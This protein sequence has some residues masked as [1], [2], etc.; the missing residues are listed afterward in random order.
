MIKVFHIITRLDIGGAEKVALNISKS[1]SGQV[2]YH[3]VEVAKGNS[4]YSEQFKKEAQ[5]SGITIHC[6]DI[7]NVRMA[8]L[9]FPLRFR[10][11]LKKYHPDVIHT[12]T[13][14]PD[15]SL[16]LSSL[17]QCFKSNDVKLV[18][19]IHNNQLWNKWK[20]IGACVERFLQKNASIVAISE[21]TQRSYQENYGKRCPI[22]YN[23]VPYTVQSVYSGLSQERLNIIFAGRM[24]YQK[25]IDTML[26]V[27]SHFGG[28][29]RFQF[30]IV[31]TGSEDD[32]V[33]AR[34]S[35]FDNV[36]ILDRIIN[37]A[38]YLGSFDY[39]FMP[40]LFEGLALT[41][42]EASFAGT[43][44]IINDVEGL[45]ETL[46]T[47][48]PLKVEDNSLEGF[49]SIFDKLALIDYSLLQQESKEYVSERFSLEKMQNNYENLYH[50][51]CR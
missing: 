33:K 7:S 1:K 29:K 8:M 44:S 35:A 32:K 49:I 34:L 30:H 9:A 39:L 28:D 27:V 50:E 4:S 25:G 2:E 42:I 20:G 13:E 23:G 47:D 19:T 10:K 6:S 5:A 45:S 24:E 17:T 11:I 22:I 40:S 38:N 16:F 31:G 51:I 46:P 26:D 21:S 12:H 41:P 14:I 48:W 36:S 43:P 18:R 3:I 15:L 37:L